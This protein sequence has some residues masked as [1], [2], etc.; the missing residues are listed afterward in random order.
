MGFKKS[1]ISALGE[2]VGQKKTES[3]PLKRQHNKQPAEIQHRSYSLKNT[4]SIWE[5]EL[6]INLRACPGGTEIFGGHL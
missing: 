2:S 1:A 4:W 5:R 6:F 3:L